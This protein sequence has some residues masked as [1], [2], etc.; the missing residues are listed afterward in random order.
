MRNTGQNVKYTMMVVVV[1]LVSAA[2]GPAA[3]PAAFAW[4]SPVAGNW[5]D[6]CQM[7][8]RPDK[9]SGARSPPAGWITPLV[10]TR[11]ALIPLTMI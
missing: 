10:L 4:N 8:E 2:A 5:S 1:G 3:T 7:D 9:G 11:L 6:R